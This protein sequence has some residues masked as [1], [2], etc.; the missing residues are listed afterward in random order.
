MTG[1][2]S[3]VGGRA[4]V[5]GLDAAVPTLLEEY[6][7]AGHLPHIARLLARGSYS[8][9]LSVFPGVTPVN[10]A[11]V[12]TGAYPGTHGVTDFRLHEPGDPFW[13][14]HKAFPSSVLQAETIW[15][16]ADRQEL[17]VA[18]LNFPGGWPPKTVRGIGIGGEGS[19]ATGSPFELRSSSC[20]ASRSMIP[21]LRDATPVDLERVG[22]SW[23]G[24][25]ELAPAND[26]RGGGPVLDI[27]LSEGENGIPEVLIGSVRAPLGNWTPWLSLRIAADGASR[28]ASTRFKLTSCSLATGAMALY[29]SQI[30]PHHGFTSPEPLGPELVN[31]FGP[32]IENV[33]GRGYERGWI[34]VQT[35][36]EEAE[37]KGMWLT[38]AARYLAEDRHT[39]LILLKW[40]FLD[41]VQHLFWGHIDPVSPWYSRDDS[42]KYEEIM[43]R[44]YQIADNMVGELSPLLDA[45]YT[46]A[47]VSDHGHI[48]HLKAMSVNNLLAKAGLL[49]WNLKDG[50]AT[51]NWAQTKAYAGPC[52]GHVWINLRGRDPEGCVSPQDY[53]AVQERIIDTLTSFRDLAAGKSPVVLA[54]K[55]DEAAVLGQWGKRTGDVVYLMRE[56]YTGDSNW[57]PLTPEGRVVVPLGPSVRH[58][59]EMGKGFVAAKFQS[60][61]GCGLPTSTLGRGTEQAILAMAGPGIKS[62]YKKTSP[63]SLTR[64]AATL[65]AVLGIRPPAQ[66]EAGPITEFFT[67]Q[68]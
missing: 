30:V 61:H 6:V 38:R 67:D 24:Q 31:R 5:I 64:V 7:A 8:R 68:K 39:D 41:H 59:I 15:E 27:T 17:L 50:R 46:L 2:N 58:E 53:V 35:L 65:A 10:W 51:V 49:V 16:A 36:L 54:L 43:V 60:T 21:S 19:P 37:Y 44:S 57:F 1:V 42:G 25:I 48:P 32:F 3:S 18:T 52:L 26:P 14:E 45:G 12:A 33:G 47:I 23:K 29:C 4:I 11:T 62:N 34:D 55:K 56:G 9:A 22:Q 63:T 13:V 40:H 28:E 20:F 66:A